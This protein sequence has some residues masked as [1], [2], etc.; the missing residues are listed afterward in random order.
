MRF[1]F[2]RLGGVLLGPH[3]R[4]FFE[5]IQA[6]LLIT[7]LASVFY[8]NNIIFTFWN[9]I[10]SNIFFYILRICSQWWL[11]GIAAAAGAFTAWQNSPPPWPDEIYYH[12]FPRHHRKFGIIFK[13]KRLAVIAAGWWS[14]VHDCVDALSGGP[15]TTMDPL[16]PAWFLG[17]WGDHGL[18]RIDPSLPPTSLINLDTIF[19]DFDP[20]SILSIHDVMLPFDGVPILDETLIHHVHFTVPEDLSCLTGA[21]SADT[22]LVVDTGASVCVSPHRSDF[23]SYRPS[24][25]TVKDLSSSNKVAGEGIIEWKLRDVHGH[26]VTVRVPGCHIE[27][28]SV[29]LLSP[30]VLL[31][32]FNGDGAL[33]PDCIRLNLSADIILEAT[34]CDRSNLP[35]LV[36][37]VQS[38][39][40]SLACFF[41]SSSCNSHSDTKASLLSLLHDGNANLSAAQKNVLSWHYRL[42]HASIRLIQSLMRDRTW[43]R[44]KCGTASLHSGP[45]LPCVER[46]PTCDIQ[47]LK[48]HACLHAK[49]H[50]RT[51]T[52]HTT[53]TPSPSQPSDI[54]RKRVD[55]TSPGILK[56][57]HLHPGDCVSADHYLSSVPG[58]LYETFGRERTGYTCGSI[59]VDHAS[60]RVFNFCQHSI[61]AQSTLRSKRSLEDIARDD[62]IVIK[63]YHSDNGIFASAAF[64]ASCSALGQQI[65]YSG[66]GAHHQNGI[67]ERNIKTVT[68]LARANLLH[69]ASHWPSCMHIK[70]WPQAVDYAI[71]VFNRLPSRNSGT[72]PLEIWSQTRSLSNELRRGHVFGCPVYVLDPVLQDGGKIPKWNPRSKLGAFMGFSNTHSSLVPL[73]LNCATGKISPQYHVVFDDRFD[74]VPSLPAD[75]DAN[76]TWSTIL[77]VFER[78]CYLD[79]DVDVD[80]VH[81]RD[82]PT[83]FD[84]ATLRRPFEDTPPLELDHPT[85]PS[86]ISEGDPAPASDIASEEVVPAPLDPVAEGVIPFMNDLANDELEDYQDLP[87]QPA[88]PPLPL[89]PQQQFHPSGRPKRN[90]L[91]YK[92][93]PAVIRRLPIDGEEY[94]LAFVLHNTLHQPAPYASNHGL[95]SPFPQYLHRD[96]LLDCSILQHQWPTA[97]CDDLH[98]FVSFDHDSLTPLV[99]DIIDPRI[100]QAAKYSADILSYD[101]AMRGPF[102]AEFYQA[103]R[104]E[105]HTLV[106][107]FKCWELV[108]RLP[109]MKVLP[110]TWNFRIKRYPD[111]SVKKFKARF[112]ACG[113][114][115]V[116]GVDFFETWAPVAQWSTIR[117]VMILAIKLNWCS[118]QCDITAAFIHAHLPAS[119]EIYVHQPRGFNV[120]PNHVLRLTRTLYGLRQSPRHFFTYLTERLVR[121]GLKPSNLDPC[122]FLS[123]DLIVI[124]YVDDLLIYAQNESTIDDFILRMN[125]EDVALRKEGTAEGY[126]G[127]DIARVDASIH[128]TQV[129]LTRRI[130]AALGL[131]DK[132]SNSCSTPCE[133]APLP[134]DENGEPASGM[135]NYASVV[136]MLLYLCGHSRPDISF[137]VHQ[138]ARYSFA[139]TR[140]HEQA[141]IRIGRYLKGTIDKGIILNPCSELRLDCYPDADFAGLW[142][143]EDSHDPHCVRS[144]TGYVITFSD[145]PVIWVSKLQTAIALSTMEAEYIALSQSCKDLFPIMDLINEISTTMKL[146]FQP[147]P[148]LHVKIHED[149]VGA[150]TLGKLEPR[151]MTPRS[152]HYALKYHWFREHIG[153]RNIILVKIDTSDQLGDIFTKGLGKVLFQ[154]LRKKLM[155]W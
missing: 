77:K 152:K 58:R 83:G 130:I 128:L 125:S 150:L 111:G 5:M 2:K 20:S 72:S 60:G 91:D 112:C 47:G 57:D 10:E 66:V 50:R 42:S 132:Y 71:W 143:H 126:L 104:E 108:P 36:M 34:Y 24:T 113:N 53:A 146:P 39:S 37:A 117:T 121:Q 3:Y 106:N 68:Q 46:G 79:F 88:A 87:T 149:N 98:G 82:P 61:D 102:Q 100:L 138:C 44:T 73:V 80:G 92:H 29:R 18:P 11:K 4:L 127:V 96:T 28:I 141:L 13:A 74:T 151:R 59:F 49:A 64:K 45:F 12:R 16:L 147:S 27:G 25:K 9:I 135:I 120:K 90:V 115:Q 63:K 140:R 95:R 110:C 116:E 114:K 136:G 35:L 7:V 21:H 22:V 75:R 38:S 78:D 137:A 89:P 124:V 144:R 6:I 67:A 8:S 107:T 26:I 99:R 153:P 62:G 43:L 118:I 81:L 69:A 70:Y 133:C 48:C 55:G 103:A 1:G 54:L 56:R 139:P 134:K 122:L 154:Q 30:R 93:G 97:S 129:G 31:R 51:S 142:S 15:P 32:S 17:E 41:S 14:L 119:E 33:L 155:G 65:R 86:T 109:H 123:K 52:I 105:L 40:H 85:A 23:V 101:D 94:D 145:C 131:D 148:H 19:G 84:W 76:L